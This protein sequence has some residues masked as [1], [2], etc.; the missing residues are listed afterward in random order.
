[1][2]KEINIKSIKKMSKLVD[3]ASQILKRD[4]T[5]KV[6]KTMRRSVKKVEKAP[7]IQVMMLGARRVGKTSVLASMVNQFNEVTGKTNLVLTKE[8]GGKEVDDALNNMKR[9]FIHNPACYE[10]APNMDTDGTSGFNYFDLKLGIYGKK[11]RGTRKIRFKDC[12]GEWITNYTNGEQIAAEVEK[13][14]VIIIAIDS[15][16]LM[17]E[18]GKYNHQNGV[19]AVTNFIKDNLNPDNNVNDHKMILFV[20][21]KCERYY[22][23][24][25]DK[26][27]IYYRRRMK[28]LTE[29]IKKS[30]ADLFVFFAKQGNKNHFDVAILPIL[31]IGGIE[32]Y[33]FEAEPDKKD[34]LT[35]EIKYV[36]CAP[37]EEKEG[38]GASPE[39]KPMY[40]E[41]PLIYTLLFECKK[42]QR[43]YMDKAFG[44]NNKKKI[45][46]NVWEWI[47][48]KKEWVKDVDYAKEMEKLEKH[49]I[50]DTEKGFEIIQGTS[51]G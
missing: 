49:V 42:I 22:W 24:N 31:T 46:A 27:G 41:Q 47:Q 35:G 45:S 33:E 25:F 6:L 2:A 26:E 19:E 39:F 34:I 44:R 50:I 3:N 5:E 21:L 13:S 8:N 11:E 37:S 17:E 16:L 48:D 9:Y 18:N 10:P 12:A 1:M 38:S 40:C 4:S 14:D 28:E 32:F 23:Q 43:E 30:Y 36:Y 20:P 15:V 51:I 7:D 29:A